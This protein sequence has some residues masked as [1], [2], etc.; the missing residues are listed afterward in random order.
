MES[1]SNVRINET[2][3]ERYVKR[4]GGGGGR[5]VKKLINFK[6]IIKKLN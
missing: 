5:R 4:E 1:S 2:Q 3:E 6:E